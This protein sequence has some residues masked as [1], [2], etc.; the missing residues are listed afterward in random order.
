MTYSL[1]RKANYLANRVYRLYILINML[2]FHT[3]M[4][5]LFLSIMIANVNVSESLEH[6]W[7][8]EIVKI[9]LN[10]GKPQLDS[11]FINGMHTTVHVV[12]SH[13]LSF[14]SRWLI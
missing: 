13:H 14:L 12:S 11:Y 4:T 1:Y 10:A 9:H 8:I 6:E 2:W 3:I 5:K 7:F